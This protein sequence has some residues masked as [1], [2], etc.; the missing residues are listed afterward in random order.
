MRTRD[1]FDFIVSMWMDAMMAAGF[2]SARWWAG[3]A[4]GRPMVNGD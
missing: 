4:M 3:V 1:P 2:T